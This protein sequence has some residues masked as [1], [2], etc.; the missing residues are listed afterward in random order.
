VIF[1]LDNPE[2]SGHAVLKDYFKSAWKAIN[3]KGVWGLFLI[4]ICL[5]IILYGSYLTFF[6]LL[7]ENNFNADSLMIGLV[8]STMSITTA[9]VSSQLGRLTRS[10]HEKTLLIFSIACYFMALMILAVAN[11]WILI[12]AAVIIFG[13]AHG[14]NPLFLGPY[15]YY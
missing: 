15:G 8:M 13:M 10:F 11:S 3:V 1:R 7:L 9:T 14:L 6:P 12:I 5:F 2:P 4:T